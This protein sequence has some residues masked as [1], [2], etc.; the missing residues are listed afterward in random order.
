MTIKFPFSGPGRPIVH[1]T[2]YARQAS[3]SSLVQTSK[4]SETF[5]TCLVNELSPSLIGTREQVCKTSGVCSEIL[6]LVAKKVLFS[7]HRNS[8]S[9]ITLGL[10][11]ASKLNLN[12]EKSRLLGCAAVLLDK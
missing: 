12:I 9:Y 6:R 1:V 5:S 3:S 8:K 4:F 7:H 10:H 11:N 2:R